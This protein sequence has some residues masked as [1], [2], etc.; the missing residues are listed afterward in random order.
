[1]TGRWAMKDGDIDYSRYTQR[2]LEEALAGINKAAWPLN[3][4]NLRAAYV[5]LA[6]SAPPPSVDA[7]PEDGVEVEPELPPTP[8]YD[9]DGRY[10]PNHIP[11]GERMGLVM[12]ALFLLAYGTHGLRA[13]DIYLPSKRGGI[14]LHDT[15]AWAMY[16]AIVCACLVLLVLIADHY[17]RRDNELNYW[18]IGRFLR[19]L[20]WICFVLSLGIELVQGART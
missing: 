14:H 11:A 16:G 12:L 13:N 6:G 15:A 8:Q 18:R 17:D 19:G 2:E 7:P 10:L 5:R 20:G 1:M 3:H 4:A 9:A